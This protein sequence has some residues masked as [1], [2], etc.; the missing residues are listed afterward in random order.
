M[1]TMSYDNFDTSRQNEYGG[2]IMRFSGPPDISTF[3]KRKAANDVNVTWGF[4]IVAYFI[5]A[6][7]C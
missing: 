5:K 1:K 3:L 7:V 4:K 6:G 2:T